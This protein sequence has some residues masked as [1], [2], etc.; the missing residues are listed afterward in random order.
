MSKLPITREISRPASSKWESSWCFQLFNSLRVLPA[1][2]STSP[3]CS[4]T[5]EVPGSSSADSSRG[6]L[7]N[8]TPSLRK[9]MLL[10]R[11]LREISWSIS[12]T[13]SSALTIS[14]RHL[15]SVGSPSFSL[16]AIWSRSLFQKRPIVSSN[17]PVTIQ[18]VVV[19]KLNSLTEQ[20]KWSNMISLWSALMSQ[21]L[22]WTRPMT[23]NY[24][25]QSRSLCNWRVLSIWSRGS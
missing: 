7:S 4:F 24:S 13:S 17:A 25:L 11:S 18:D 6:K 10:T 20:L 9:L 5:S 8:W 15:S 14:C 16:F 12:L 22:V 23:G 1:T 21:R 3:G 2:Y 19:L